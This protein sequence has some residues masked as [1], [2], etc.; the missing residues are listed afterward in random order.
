MIIFSTPNI[1][2]DC[3]N[4]NWKIKINLLNNFCLNNSYYVI[5]F[6][7][8]LQLISQISLTSYLFFQD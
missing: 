7:P 2:W 6:I 5:G 4:Y 1:F 8:Y 3:Y